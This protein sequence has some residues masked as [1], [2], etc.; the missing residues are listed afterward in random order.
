MDKTLRKRIEAQYRE[1]KGEEFRCD[2]CHHT[3]YANDYQYHNIY[4]HTSVCAS[5][6][7]KL[8]EHHVY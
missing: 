8:N 7:T 5:C 4:M 6:Y 2:H 3:I 1:Q